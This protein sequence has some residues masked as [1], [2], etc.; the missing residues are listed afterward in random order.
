M[1]LRMRM[2]VAASALGLVFA[3]G[4]GRGQDIWLRPEATSYL[5]VEF[6]KPDFDQE[7]FTSFV[8]G[9]IYLSAKYVIS[10][11][12]AVV[13]EVPFSRVGFDDGF[14]DSETLVANPYVGVELRN[15]SGPSFLEV[16]LRLP[17]ASDDKF[18]ATQVGFYTDADRFEAFLADVATV[19]IRVNYVH[20]GPS[21][22]LARL[23]IGP[24]FWV[25]TGE[26][27]ADN[28]V[29]VDYSAQLGYEG[30]AMRWLGGL[31]GRWF[32]TGEGDFGN[33]S[34][35]QFGAALAVKLGQVEPGV[36]VRVP[37]D[38]DL[39]DIIDF[40]VGFNLTVYA[41]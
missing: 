11:R 37:L 34:F 17:V 1:P 18:S 14:G 13:G 20:T 39:S 33:R 30:G 22:L 35:H 31:T 5:S 3:A 15:P 36:Q 41:R 29:F 25:D 6:L 32:A 24:S 28:E 38:E 40:V 23:R 12:V 2:T 10:E 7:S 21:G 26:T 19:A 8:T 16:G 27:L 9:V 4:A